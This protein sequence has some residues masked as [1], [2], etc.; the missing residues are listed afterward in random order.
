[1]VAWR[2]GGLRAEGEQG[3]GG[4]EAEEK[5]REGGS[6]KEREMARGGGGCAVSHTF[7][8]GN[9]YSTEDR[10]ITHTN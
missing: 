8:F 1:M 7:V 9:W 10:S 2:G 6:E 4:G 3:G 5:R